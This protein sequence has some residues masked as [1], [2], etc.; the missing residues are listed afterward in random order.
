MKRIQTLQSRLFYAT[1]R[2]RLAGKEPSRGQKRVV[3]AISKARANDEL[4]NYLVAPQLPDISCTCTYCHS[5]LVVHKAMMV[6]CNCIVQTMHRAC[7]E[8]FQEEFKDRCPMCLE[9]IHIKDSV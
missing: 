2:S 8:T 4:Y 1:V 6:E 9:K 7:L 5:K 3:E